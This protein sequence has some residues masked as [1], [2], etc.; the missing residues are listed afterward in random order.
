MR[1]T[2]LLVLCAALITGMAC[3]I[4]LDFDLEVEC[5][6][7]ERW[8]SQIAGAEALHLQGSPVPI[9][10]SETTYEA[11][12]TQREHLALDTADPQDPL[13]L[14]LRDNL[15]SGA[16]ANCEKIGAELV[17]FFFVGTTCA[18]TGIAPVATNLVHLGACWE[19]NSYALDE[20]VCPL[21]AECGPFYDCSSEPIVSVGDDE[22]GADEAGDE[23]AWECDDP[24]AV[25]DRE[26][27]PG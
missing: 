17:G 11:C 22:A 7:G 9:P 6:C 13:Y 1:W 12:V 19:T 3:S 8:V 24:V 5:W 18:T 16:I 26:F 2:W 15:E 21:D 20:E 14:A 23:V 25:V 27:D 4:L 10:A